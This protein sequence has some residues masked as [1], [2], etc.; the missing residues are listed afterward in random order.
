MT[1]ITMSFTCIKNGV[2][3]PLYMVQ[4]HYI[5]L[6]G[7]IETGLNSLF[8]V[9]KLHKYNVRQYGQ[10]DILTNTSLKYI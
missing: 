4:T 2:F 8:K 1:I 6:L 9:Q 5:R 10:P 7:R 3:I